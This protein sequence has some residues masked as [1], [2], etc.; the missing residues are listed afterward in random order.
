MDIFA[1]C[2]L[3]GTVSPWTIEK[4]SATLIAGC[5]N[6]QLSSL[7]VSDMLYEKGIFYAP[8]YVVNA[9]G[10]IQV[11]GIERSD[12]SENETYNEALVDQHLDIIPRNL[13]KIFNISNN[14]EKSTQR[15]ADEMVK[16]N[17]GLD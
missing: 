5:A 17:L 16:E 12:S 15:V 14:M 13:L 1:P 2:A 6:N 10:V 7:K 8:D 4:M 3:Y 11:I 9:G